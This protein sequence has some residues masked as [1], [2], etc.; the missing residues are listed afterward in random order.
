V[1]LDRDDGMA[2]TFVV[3]LDNVTPVR[4]ALLTELSAERMQ[5]VCDA[6]GHA[7]ACQ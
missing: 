3:S 6:L 7:T 2:T 4:P 1:E 5:A